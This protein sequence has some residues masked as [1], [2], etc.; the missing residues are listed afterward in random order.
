MRLIADL[1]LLADRPRTQQSIIATL[2]ACLETGW[3]DQMHERCVTAQGSEAD[4]GAPIAAAGA[5]GGAR[6][7]FRALVDALAA[8]Y[9]LNLPTRRANTRHHG[10]AGAMSA[11]LWEQ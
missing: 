1:D 8:E 2:R 11:A 9:G 5:T 6:A 4:R 10:G 7:A 3:P